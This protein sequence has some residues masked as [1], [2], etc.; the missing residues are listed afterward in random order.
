[1]NPLDIIIIIILA[2]CVIRGLFRGLIKELTAIIALFVGFNA[3]YNYYPILSQ[4]LAVWLPNFQYLK[5]TSFLIIFFIALIIVNII[6]IIIKYIINF[7][8]LGWIDKIFGVAFGVLKAGLIIVILA[9]IITSFIPKGSVFV[10]ESLIFP[11]LSQTSKQLVKLIPENMK[12]NLAIMM[13]ELN[14]K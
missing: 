7:A 9:A 10:S 2:Y 11:Y 6:G 13:K 1:M 5:I 3:A 12:N 4:Q 14:E 8:F